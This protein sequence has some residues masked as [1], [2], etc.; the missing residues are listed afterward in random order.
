M[1][2]VLS[3]YFLE[4]TP[5]Q[6]EEMIQIANVTDKMWRQWGISTT[7]MAGII[8]AKS[9]SLVKSWLTWLDIES[10]QRGKQTNYEKN[11]YHEWIMKNKW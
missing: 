8:Q 3:K 4:L 5:T 2:L 10:P 7:L 11:F 1:F 9:R 6:M